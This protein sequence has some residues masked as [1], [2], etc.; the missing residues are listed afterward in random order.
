MGALEGI[1]G[2]SFAVEFEATA[3]EAAHSHGL[4]A[5][6]AAF[7]KLSNLKQ[8]LHTH[9]WSVSWLRER[10]CVCLGGNCLGEGLSTSGEGFSDSGR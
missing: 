4:C 6:V 9:L 8:K 5:T 2:F 7:H 1:M 10:M 3:R